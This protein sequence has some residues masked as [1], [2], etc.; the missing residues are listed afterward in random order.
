MDHQK[1]SNFFSKKDM[2]MQTETNHYKLGMEQN[3]EVGGGLAGL[4][5]ELLFGLKTRHF[6]K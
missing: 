1:Q 4:F 2:D 5:Y 6:Q 3:G